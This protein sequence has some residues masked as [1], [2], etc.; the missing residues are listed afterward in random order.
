MKRCAFVIV[1]LFTI[2]L[3]SWSAAAIDQTLKLSCSDRYWYPF[4]FI[5]DG[6]VSGIFYD[7]TVKALERLKIEARIEPVPF[8]RAIANARKGKVDGVIGVGFHPDLLQALV[9]PPDA[10][11]DM[12]SPWRILQVDYVIVS[13]IEDSYEFEGNLDTLPLPVRLLQ[14]AP[15]M[16]DLT[17]AGIDFQE[18]REDSQNFLKLIRD[19][20]G[21]VITTSVVAE[22]MIQNPRF[23]G[24][25]KIHGTPAA[26]HSYY[27]AFSRK[28]RLSSED[29][30]RIWKEVMRWRDDY[31]FILQVYSQY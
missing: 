14:D 9:F 23:T 21:T 22:A 10:D 4:L 30:E 18:V 24:K 29:K 3:Y 28:S 8:R 31:I 13:S 11:K 19:K 16:E 7:I 12:E 20:K 26:S 5:Q 27:L 17:N 25:I 6:Q 1:M 15:I 2:L